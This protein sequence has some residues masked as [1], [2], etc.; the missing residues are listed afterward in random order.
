MAVDE[1]TFVSTISRSQHNQ[2]KTIT[3][4]D[5]SRLYATTRHLYSDEESKKD[6]V[7]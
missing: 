7:I 5:T 1:R 2:K 3:E 4:F 6:I